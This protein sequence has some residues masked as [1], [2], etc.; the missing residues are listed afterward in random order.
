MRN[1]TPTLSKIGLV[2]L[3]ALSVSLISCQDSGN[4][5]VP[6]QTSQTL[7]VEF[8][9]ITLENG[10]DVIFH[11]D[12]SDP[13]VAINI[14]AH[15]GSARET[16]G[17]TG[18]A[19]LFEHL[20]FLD[21]ENLGYGGLDK[22][23]TRI[24]GEGTNGFTTHDMTQYFQAAPKDA[25]EKI[26][27][28]EADK[29]CCFISTVSQNVIDN[30]KQVVKNEKRQRDDNQAYGHNFYIINKA[31][32]PVD[33][34][35][36]WQVIGSLDD[37]DAA[38]LEDTKDFYQRWYAPNNVTVT[39]AG[40]F[41]MD[42]AKRLMRKYFEDIPSG[43]DIEKYSPRP[44]TLVETKS[45][46]YEDNFATV[47]QLTIVW[48]TVEQYHPDSYALNILM[49]YLTDGKSAP[50]SQ[51]L[52]DEE[53]LTS[54]VGGF[55]YVKEIAGEA[56]ISITPNDGQDID[57]LMPALDIAFAR[58]EE[59]SI[60]A[61]DL[62]RIKAGLEV[63]FFNN[64]QSALG[65]AIA[66]GEYNLFADDPGFI[67]TDIERMQS[68]T[69]DDVM[70]VY[71]KYLKDQPRL[72]TSIVPM[73][74]TE[75]V[76]D[77]ATKA[78][79][80]EEKVV[81]GEGAPIDFIPAER[82]I[83]N[84]SGFERP[85]PDFG[86]SY[87]LTS[88]NVWKSE[89]EN[90]IKLFGINSQEIPVVEFSIRIDAGNERGDYVKPAIPD[91][92]SAL[93]EKGTANKTT[94]E[95][96]D[97]IQSLGSQIS[98]STG[99]S[100]TF[101]SGR[102]LTRNFDATM[103]L[104]QEMILEPRWDAEE[105]D[106]LK[107]KML[108]DIDQIAGN[109]NA[110]AAQEM[111]KLRYPEGHILRY[112][113]TGPKDKLEAVTLDDLRAFY[114]KNYTQHGMLIRIAGD[115]DAASV[116]SSLAGFA[117]LDKEEVA[118]ISLNPP[119]A[120]AETRIYFYDMPDAKQSVLRMER[121]AMS[122]LDDD[123]RLA[124]DINFPLGGIYTSKLMTTLRVD[125]GY[126]YGIRS[127]F[128]GGRDRG[129]FTIGSS[130]RT[131]V[132]KESIELILD[133]IGRYGSEF[134]EADLATMKEALIR[135][136]ALENETLADKLALVRDISYYDFPDDFKSRQAEQTSN[137][138]LAKVKELAATH[139]RPDAMRILVVGDAASQ[140]ESVKSLGLPV[141]VLEK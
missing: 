78:S 88:P 118:S 53:K 11:V 131:N 6:A 112:A 119:N 121:P 67:V 47:P 32:Y 115:V 19:H 29:L 8:E 52:V 34:P 44:S 126:T 50:L 54:S 10:L 14:A 72:Y 141:I 125:K 1:L 23:N 132:T 110:I 43:P 95:L 42:E 64:M 33:H 104:V 139:I 117:K 3:M 113:Y 108:N 4:E 60:P 90:G 40:D 57:G 93:L 86:E 91:M 134:N 122:V 15:V 111:A 84:P 135:G 133:I 70:R 68:V 99:E 136:Q 80:V 123:Y 116:S 82:V 76:L 94:A 26:I 127:R 87:N 129:A 81:A 9:K 98:L 124:Q 62:D 38:S 107:R 140:L 45:L 97:A 89:L 73:G 105:F 55:H 71:N 18:F 61:S 41:D 66:L 2:S 74:E 25:L 100:G 37:L 92:L 35:Y 30:E 22:M 24:G 79:I 101:I 109:P 7:S 16:T 28:A 75:L 20:L 106:L 39:L 96:E 102:S 83:E 31:L 49:D 85:E 27:W 65:K 137:L 69:T 56:Y 77:G 130:V 63:Q 120:V 48:P 138:T 13:V 51:V 59:N 12:R 128:S 103:G 5:A 36:N 17:R 58:F 46:Y 21:S 114:A